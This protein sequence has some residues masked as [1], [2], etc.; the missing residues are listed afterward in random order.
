MGCTNGER[1][2]DDGMTRP[3]WPVHT[4]QRAAI[5]RGLE[6]ARPVE[7][8]SR[9]L[10]C[11]RADHRHPKVAG[12]WV[13]L[14]IFTALHALR[15]S[16]DC[17]NNKHPIHLL[18]LHSFCFH[19][20]FT[21]LRREYVPAAKRS[22]SGLLDFSFPF[23]SRSCISRYLFKGP[24]ERHRK[25]RRPK[26][27]SMLN[28]YLTPCSFPILLELHVRRST[29]TRMQ[30]ATIDPLE[31]IRTHFLRATTNSVIHTI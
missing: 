11:E 30:H 5:S 15:K 25:S 10:A 14:Q 20:L 24:H 4:T 26:S 12:G 1:R 3:H 9:R 29:R 16:C 18:S 2:L 17:Y 31:T 22:P 8:K 13:F 27:L 19:L 21:R 7:I 28:I 6:P 23:T